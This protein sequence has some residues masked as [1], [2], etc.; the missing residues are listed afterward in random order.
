METLTWIYI[1]M[2]FFGNFFLIMFFLL[3]FRN[4]EILF[5][6]QEPKEFPDVTFLVPAYNEQDSIEGTL[7]ALMKVD[8]P[9][10]KKKILVVNDGSEDGTSKIV[11]EFMKMHDNVD[12]LDKENS[13]KANSLN[14]ALKLVDTELFA[15]VDAD[16]YPL[17]DAL[18]KMTGYFEGN[19]EIAAVTSR[20]L[21]KNNRNFIEMFQ[22]VDYA[23]IAWS[24]KILDF[25]DS[26][27]V[28]NGPLSVY[29]TKYVKEVGGFDPKNLTEDI[30]LT[31]KLLSKG[32]RTKMSYSAKVFTV[33]PS[34]LRGWV[35]Q[36]IR[37][38]I[39]GLQTIYKYRS[40]VFR[41]ENIF[42]YFVVT[43]VAL[44]F[45]LALIGFVLFAR[46]FWM[47]FSFY[48]FSLPY[49]FQGYNVLNFI[50]F[51]FSI[52]LIL[53]MG[54]MFFVL[55]FIYYKIALKN[56]DLK[57]KSI[58]TIL[59]YLLVYRPLYMIPLLRCLYK[60]ARRDIRWYTK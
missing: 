52:S 7:K 27:Y 28:T 51:E 32:Y 6:Y 36:R 31:W 33:V 35:N 10:D 5:D 15:V 48:L 8:Y 40:S 1:V 24:R 14:Q 20:V 2:F 13:G 41:G 22:A 39:G 11:R 30:E 9:K 4:R 54:L 60:I 16:S 47:E 19:D 43:Y 18:L 49:V 38:N 21:V 29:R 17:P 50:N 55:S 45:L 37:W 53:I 59:T 26:V 44:S 12:I 57:S 42:G 58:L 56:D 25:V 46:F 23:V 34:T 3:Y